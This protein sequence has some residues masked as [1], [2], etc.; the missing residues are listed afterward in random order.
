LSRHLEHSL[1]VIAQE[2]FPT[3][4]V[5][6]RPSAEGEE[7]ILEISGETTIFLGRSRNAAI[8][9]LLRLVEARRRVRAGTPPT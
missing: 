4:A 9:E 5:F 6:C 7:W 3:A 8:V 2:T 1:T